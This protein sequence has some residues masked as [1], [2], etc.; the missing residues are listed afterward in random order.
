MHQVKFNVVYSYFF[1]AHGRPHAIGWVNA[2]NGLDRWLGMLPVKI[3]WPERYS[4][5]F[6]HG[7]CNL[8]C[9][10]DDWIAKNNPIIKCKLKKL[11][12]SDLDAIWI[13]EL[14]VRY[15]VCQRL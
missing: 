11:Y 3:R 7:L 14:L 2:F 8:Q 9:D 1:M 15:P 6:K 4:T 5:W 10:H 12:N 13:V